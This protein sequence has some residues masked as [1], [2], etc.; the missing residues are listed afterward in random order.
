MWDGV[1]IAKMGDGHEG[2]IVAFEIS[3]RDCDRL[4]KYLDKGN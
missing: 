4:L 3:E 2:L 1:N